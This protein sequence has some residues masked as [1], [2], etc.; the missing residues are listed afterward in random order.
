LIVIL[1]AGFMGGIAGSFYS[2]VYLG[3]FTSGI[4]GGR[5]WIAF[6]ICF[7]GNWNPLGAMVGA[8]IF[9]IAEALA[10]YMQSSGGGV[11]P[12]EMLI[13]MPYIL[14]IVLT[15]S[16]KKFNVP[17]KLGTPYIKEH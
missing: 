13:A 5:G 6:A 9:G 1:I 17:T 8:L 16:R 3:M 4:I 15:I 2:I 11:L 7:L 12:N 14:T 10:I